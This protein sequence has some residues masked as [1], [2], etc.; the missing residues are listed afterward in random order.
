MPTPTLAIGHGSGVADVL[1]RIET[2]ARRSDWTLTTLLSSEFSIAEIAPV[3]VAVG[4]NDPM[5]LL[6]VI[7]S[8]DGNGAAQLD[9]IVNAIAEIR[10]QILDDYPAATLHEWAI[11]LT[12]RRLDPAERDLLATLAMSLRGVAVTASSTSETLEHTT[13]DERAFAADLGAVLAATTL[14]REMGDARSVWMCSVGSVSYSPAR[15]ALAG[16]AAQVTAVIDELSS[17]GEPDPN[18]DMGAIWIDDFALVEPGAAEALLGAPTGGSL[19][20]RIR[21]GGI[22]FAKLPVEDWT[23]AIV[24]RHD[25]AALTEI[26]YITDRIHRNRHHGLDDLR[27]AVLRR[28]FEELEDTANIATARAFCDGMRTALDQVSGALEKTRPPTHDDSTVEDRVMLHNLLR[29]LPFGPAVATR[30]VMM[31]L[32]VLIMVATLSDTGAVPIDLTASRWPLSAAGVVVTV[33]A[34]L[35]GRRLRRTIRVRNRLAHGLEQR[36]VR[37]VEQTALEAH[38]E[39]VKSLSSWIGR[40]PTRDPLQPELPTR[41]STVTEWLALLATQSDRARPELTRRSRDRCFREL[42]ATPYAV[43]LPTPDAV[44]TDTLIESAEVDSDEDAR[45]VIRAITSEV[46]AEDLVVLAPD[47]LIDLW[48]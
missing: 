21:F 40:D 13:S 48:S 47:R 5:L 35:Y 32:F 45:R 36:L 15:L 26:P 39:M 23:D 7:G 2:L 20:A 10:R 14:E 43:D 29:W 16:A 44:P 38:I 46:T 17:P 1:A 42:G 6:H 31:A 4:Q 22:D 18:H 3:V 19:V 11:V 34:G 24:T 41:A 12:G 27:T 9:P 25:M 33:G 8:G 28:T 30:L 37:I